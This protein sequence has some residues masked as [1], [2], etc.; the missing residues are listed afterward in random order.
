MVLSACG[1]EKLIYEDVAKILKRV[2]E[3]LNE[4]TE[5]NLWFT[6]GRNRKSTY[7]NRQ[8]ND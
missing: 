7:I 3:T 4:E 6:Y 2:F 8:N 1:K 5:S